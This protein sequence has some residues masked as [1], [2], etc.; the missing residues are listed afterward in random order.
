[1]QLVK[2]PFAGRLSGFTLPFEA[3]VL[4]LAPE[5]PFAAVSRNA[6]HRGQ[7]R[8]SGDCN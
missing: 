4:M 2:P 1:V 3:L 6:A 5:M 7:H 8:F